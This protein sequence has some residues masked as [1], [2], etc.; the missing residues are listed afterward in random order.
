MKGTIIH[1]VSL[2]LLPAALSM[3]LRLWFA[4]CRV[5]E[6]GLQNRQEV[7]RGGSIVAVFWHYCLV[8]VFY[9]LKDDR[10]AVLVSASDD[11]DYIARLARCLNFETVRGSS[12]RRGLLAL[13]ELLAHL[14]RGTHVGMVGDG[15]QGPPLVAQ[16]GSVLLASR[17]GAPI[18]P[19]AWS[20]SRTLTFNSWDHTCIPQPFS[21]IDFH[22]GTPITVP[23]GVD[24]EQIEHYRL[25]LEEEMNGLYKTAW[26][27]YGKEKHYDD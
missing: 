26:A 16:A 6:H 19:I 10:A 4:T 14:A 24:R 7:D 2:A 23:P 22:Y 18:L 3:L 27:L 17:S 25:R 12:N 21:R 5:T 8:Y 9:H 20:A 1:R 15:S 11:G 13:K